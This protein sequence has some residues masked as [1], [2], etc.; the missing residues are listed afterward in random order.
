M[1]DLITPN[2]FR[3]GFGTNRLGALSGRERSR[4]LSC[5]WDLGVR[6]FDTAPLYGGGDAERWLGE[7][8]ATG[9]Q[10]ATVT[11]KFGLYPAL[12]QRSRLLRDFARM[13]RR[14]SGPIW[15]LAGKWI[16]K[17][18]ATV[19]RPTATRSPSEYRQ[20]ASGMEAALGVSL[21]KLRRE[22]VDVFAI[23][24]P[25]TGIL[26]ADE[27][28]T[29]L[30]KLRAAGKT[31]RVAAAGC[32]HAV[33]PIAKRKDTPFDIYQFEHDAAGKNMSQWMEVALPPPILF[34]AVAARGTVSPSACGHIGEAP[35][36]LMKSV[37]EVNL[38]GLVL[39]STTKL[40]HAE[41]ILLPFAA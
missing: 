29:E 2:G 41:E 10:E 14:F 30:V 6:H 33:F 21:G 27:V 13:A 39:F 37:L 18:Q 8:L 4:L 24:E 34:G 25:D 15:K 22:Y 23:H 5:V 38:G 17:P 40:T 11:T 36:A 9:R 31:K 16:H 7:F 12:V 3:I 35:S 26:E 32:F 28:L 19:P 1:K 20:I